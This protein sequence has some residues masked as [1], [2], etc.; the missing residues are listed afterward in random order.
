M[1][2][3]SKHVVSIAAVIPSPEREAIELSDKIR[4]MTLARLVAM[5]GY[6]HKTLKWKNIYYDFYK[7]K[8]MAELG[9]K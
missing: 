2:F 4:T 6:K 8:V 1:Y 9:V 7:K 3:A 5:P